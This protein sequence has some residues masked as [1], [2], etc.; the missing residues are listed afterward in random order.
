MVG[1]ESFLRYVLNRTLNL[2]RSPCRLI[3]LLKG[4]KRILKIEEEHSDLDDPTNGI[5]VT[6][7]VMSTAGSMLV[8]GRMK[9]IH[10]LQL[11]EEVR[12]TTRTSCSALRA[13]IEPAS[14]ASLH[15]LILHVLIWLASLAAH[16]R[17]GCRALILCGG[18]STQCTG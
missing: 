18:R 11:Y 8:L 14:I 17:T 16:L 5:G 2:T 3:L 1:G 13:E 10:T 15:S 6:P 12:T 4:S 9:Q 7:A